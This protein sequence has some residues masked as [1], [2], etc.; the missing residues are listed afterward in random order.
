MSDAAIG[1]GGDSQ[2]TLIVRTGLRRS[3]CPAVLQFQL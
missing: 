3:G 2:Q 1:V